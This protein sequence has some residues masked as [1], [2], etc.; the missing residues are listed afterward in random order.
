MAFSLEQDRAILAV[1][2]TYRNVSTDDIAMDLSHRAAFF[3]DYLEES[4][5]KKH[6]EEE[7]AKRLVTLRKLGRVPRKFRA[8]GLN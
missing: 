2:A 5:D 6:S 8:I 4:G 7:V 3:R 1:Y